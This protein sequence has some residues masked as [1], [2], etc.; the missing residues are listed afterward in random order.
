MRRRGGGPRETRAALIAY[1]KENNILSVFHYLSLNESSFYRK[2]HDG[3]KLVNSDYYTSR[4]LRLPLY[5]EMEMSQL[6][7]VTD[8]IIKFYS[9]HKCGEASMYSNLLL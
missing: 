6:D 4:L 5:F 9:S 1:L 3:R 7:L 2:K 8:H